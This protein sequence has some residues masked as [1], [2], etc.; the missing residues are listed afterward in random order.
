MIHCRTLGTIAIQ[1]SDS[2]APQQLTWR[3][4][5]ALL[6]YLARSPHQRRSRDHLVGLLWPEKPEAAARHSLNE[7]LRVIRRTAGDE[8]VV[9]E[10][11]YL[12]LAPDVVTLDVDELARLVES[13]EWN[14][15]ARLVNGEFLE[16][17]AV[18]EASEFDEWLTHERLHWHRMSLRALLASAEALLASG[19]V[20]EAVKQA[21]RARHLEPSSEAATSI[22]MRAL[23]VS[24]NR[25][26][27][28]ERYAD[29]VTSL[30][31]LQTEP[32]S[33]IRA[34]AQRLREGR[35]SPPAPGKTPP[36]RPSPLIGRETELGELTNLWQRCRNGGPASAAIILGD[37][38]TGKS[39]LIEELVLRAVMDGASVSRARAVESD[40]AESLNGI[41]TLASGRLIDFPAVAAAPEEALA[42]LGAQ[43]GEWLERFPATRARH[44]M[45]IPQAL[46]EVLRVSSQ[47]RPVLLILDDAHW[48]DGPSLLAIQGLLRDLRECP[49]MVVLAAALQPPRIELESM[50]ADIGHDVPGRIFKLGPLSSTAMGQLARWWLPQ[51]GDGEIE[52]VVRRVTADSAGLPLLAVELFRAVALGMDVLKLDAW[53]QPNKT[54]D[55]TLP[56]DLPP[57]VVAA[58]RVAFRRLTK[59]AQQ[60]LATGSVLSKPVSA[61]ELARA[62]A[63]SLDET[64]AALD[65][66]EWHRWMVAE[67][68]GYTF[69]ARIVQATIA[70]DMLT[71]GQRRRLR[72]P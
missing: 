72:T 19:L 35:P 34:L 5:L 41:R 9:S 68:R 66:L 26:G 71:E 4:N 49:I 29:L 13:Q 10:T 45:S 3:K 6:V 42:N 38:G 8:A 60:V 62:T 57:S 58:I 25:A 54:L 52:R 20:D 18:P 48:L 31:S 23:A 14:A 56:S 40:S 32:G 44:T 37:A 51:Y 70:R 47:E 65:E 27:A 69:V 16:G 50:I 46:I 17:F 2:A 59:P 67:A 64:H 28:L 43:L 39:R 1:V 11:G 21:E 24:G 15:A 53:P 33:E 7:A 61:D 55:Q 22:A 30:R 36:P 12:R 63:L